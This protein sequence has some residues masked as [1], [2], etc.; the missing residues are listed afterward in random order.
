MS[1]RDSPSILSRMSETN[2]EGEPKQSIRILEIA[3]GFAL[4]MTRVVDC[5]A[6]I[7][8]RPVLTIL[9]I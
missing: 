8:S 1:L 5:F 3:T 2:R 9:G 7:K 4:A 6:L